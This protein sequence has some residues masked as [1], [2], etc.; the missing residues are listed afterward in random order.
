[1]VALQ[2]RRLSDAAEADRHTK[3]YSRE[4]IIEMDDTAS[5][6]ITDVLTV[7]V[8]VTDQDRALAF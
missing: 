2:H 5:H 6:T 8:P 3:P 7:G 4:R 1:V